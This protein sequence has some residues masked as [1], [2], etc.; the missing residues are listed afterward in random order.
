MIRVR[1]L[2]TARKQAAP[3][4][5][6]EEACNVPLRSRE[7]ETEARRVDAGVGGEYL[8][9]RKT[10]I[11]SRL[12]A[13]LGIFWMLSRNNAAGPGAGT[14]E[15]DS[16]VL[17]QLWQDFPHPPSS[18][19]EMCHQCQPRAG[20]GTQTLA[21]IRATLF[22]TALT[23]G[24]TPA[25]ASLQRKQARPRPSPVCGRGQQRGH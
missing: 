24:S 10:V 8:H 9:I 25:K 1:P 21:P 14:S 18:A 20:P 23:L 4:N 7:R 3:D 11:I 12:T 19:K 2:W 16:R 15:L 17:G 6:Q 13:L 22:S 5:T